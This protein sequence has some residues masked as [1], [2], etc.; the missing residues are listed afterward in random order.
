MNAKKSVLYSVRET[1]TLSGWMNPIYFCLIGL[2]VPD[3][4]KWF[5]LDFVKSVSL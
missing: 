3:V 1:Y 2:G 5:G 4:T